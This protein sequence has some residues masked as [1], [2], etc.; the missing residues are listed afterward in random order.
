MS[1]VTLPRQP[2]L[3]VHEEM[4]RRL[5]LAETYLGRAILLNNIKSPTGEYLAAW[6]SYA[7]LVYLWLLFLAKLGNTAS[8]PD[9]GPRTHSRGVGV[10]L[11]FYGAD[12]LAA[13][14]RAG[15]VVNAV[16]GEPWHVQLPDYLTYPIVKT[17]T[18]PLTNGL[19]QII[20][21]EDNMLSVTDLALLQGINEKIDN[22]QRVA[23]NTEPLLTG[24]NSKLDDITGGVVKLLV[25]GPSVDGDDSDDLQAVAALIK[26]LPAETVAALKAAL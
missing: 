17:S 12:V 18:R 6:R 2:H 19:G 3:T 23:G 5:A 20:N 21:P 26:A 14:R 11:M 16:K 1:F 22:L 7:G 25:R 15:L 13:C 24:M 9:S 8:N 10:D 4:A